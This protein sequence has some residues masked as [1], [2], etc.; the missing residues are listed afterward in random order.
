MFQEK[1]IQLQVAIIIKDYECED[2]QFL[3]AHVSI[4]VP[5]NVYQNTVVHNDFREV[6][7]V[8]RNTEK[9]ITLV[10]IKIIILHTKNTDGDSR[11]VNWD[12]LLMSGL[13]LLLVIWFCGFHLFNTGL[14]QYTTSEELI[15]Y[16][17]QQRELYICMTM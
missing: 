9:F 16:T 11:S 15:K 14:F 12:D 2:D 17:N 5:S 13:C 7:F 6:D 4:P 1:Y 10:S 8:L 3:L